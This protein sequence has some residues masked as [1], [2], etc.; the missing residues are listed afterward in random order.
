MRRA[1][2]TRSARREAVAEAAI[3]V[4]EREAPT[5]KGVLLVTGAEPSLG[6]SQTIRCANYETAWPQLNALDLRGQDAEVPCLVLD[7]EDQ[8]ASLDLC[9]RLRSTPRLAHLPIIILTDTREAAMAVLTAGANDFC[10]R[11]N[12]AIELG[13][14]VAH[15]L[16]LH[17]RSAHTLRQQLLTGAKERLHRLLHKT[18]EVESVLAEIAG[19]IAAAV[20][21]DACGLVVFGEG[22]D[23]VLHRA[24]AV[25][26]EHDESAAISLEY[27]KLGPNPS[28]MAHRPA[29][30]IFGGLN[31]SASAPLAEL[32]W[33][34]NSEGQQLGAL[35][36]GIQ[37]E[38]DQIA[39][40][41][42]DGVALTLG[43]ALANARLYRQSQQT[44]EQLIAQV[45]ERQQEIERQK[46][47]TEKIIDSLPVSLYVVDRQLR[48]VAWNRN[49]EIG[50]QGIDRQRVIGRS[51]V[52]IFSKMPR[53]MLEQEFE[54]VFTSGE[55]LRFEQESNVEGVSRHWLIS[56][57]PMRLDGEAVTH[58]I[59]LGEE[60]TEQKKMNE[61]ILHAEKLTGIGRLA[62]GVVHEIN[63]PLATIAAC[64][65]ALQ[66]RLTEATA[67]SEAT[68]VDFH[69]YLKIIHDESFRCKMITNSL[70]EFSRQRQAEKTELEINYLVE[71]TLQ[72][73]KHH[74]KF[75]RL[76]MLKELNADLA[77]VF[78]N[79]GQLKQ[80]FIAMISNAF[81]AMD[82]QGCLR[83]RTGWHYN[84][85]QR[86]IGAEFADNGCGIR[87]EDVAK[88]F[89]PFFTTKP[90]GQGTGLGL[91]VCY[92]IVS[93]HRGK[94]E[95]D[96]QVGRGT[97]MRVL[98]PPYI[99]ATE[100]QKN[101][102]G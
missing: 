60:I 84:K 21:A 6:A 14:R 75:K 2:K 53:Q 29:A 11:A 51:V 56:K 73:V 79:E 81:D 76:Q 23:A 78:A 102:Q 20:C 100:A 15:C 65:E 46:R 38:F 94:I 58:V 82:E 45:R 36:C 5:P 64:A 61:A 59:T 28:L 8:A 71:Q 70:L 12:A 3:G 37:G 26:A 85:G 72:L 39:M 44:S 80:V 97:T 62:S 13:A 17:E 87:P 93:D 9:R 91:A 35:A 4:A 55:S 54:R 7:F 57:I 19:E 52:D 47:L 10:L 25:S 18:L 88:I 67:L 69:E 63:N 92:G 83:I 34:L 22:A 40:N 96:S 32:V 95:V 43:A 74:P 24:L 68:Q 27:L 77:P 31:G 42:L 99:K 66:G 30:P 49:R 33:P 89:E 16:R 98:L 101:A 90:F 41:W 50:G 86:F 1:V 48:I